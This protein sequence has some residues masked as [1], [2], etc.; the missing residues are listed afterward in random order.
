M[1]NL[2]NKLA[3]SILDPDQINIPKPDASPA[4]IETTLTWFIALIAAICFLVIVIAG[5]QFIIAAGEPSKIAKAR[6]TILYAVVGLIIS[7]IAGTIVG[8]VTGKI[9]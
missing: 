1:N 8:F 2:F 3:E 4:L 7:L 5:F 9:G 6:Q